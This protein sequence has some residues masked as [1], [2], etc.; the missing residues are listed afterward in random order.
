VSRGDRIDPQPVT[1]TIVP[2]ELAERD[3]EALAAANG[4]DLLLERINAVAVI[5]GIVAALAFVLGA[6]LG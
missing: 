4:R 3:E 2:S 5:A 6:I 1:L